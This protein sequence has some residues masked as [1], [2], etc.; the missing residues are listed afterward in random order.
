MSLLELIIIAISL[1]MDA[2]TV[3]MMYG[4]SMPEKNIK[5]QSF[6][7]FYFGFFQAL[8][9]YLGYHLGCVFS[10]KVQAYDHYVAF[11][12]LMMVGISMLKD[13]FNNEET[14][15]H[16]HFFDLT[17]LAI[18]TSIDDFSIGITFAFLNVSLYQSIMIIGGITFLL[19]FIALQIG[20]YLNNKFQNKAL[21][22][23]GIV[24][25]LMAFKTLLEHLF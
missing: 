10:K 15:Y 5:K 4:I 13:A 6:I 21:I 12:F 19:C 22:F 3:S 17:I 11:I 23:G 9:P 1:A 18:A 7:A 2:F 8:M 25:I 16:F 20:R 24:L 14:V